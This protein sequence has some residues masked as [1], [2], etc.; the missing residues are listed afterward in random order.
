MTLLALTEKSF[1]FNLANV[2]VSAEIS[3]SNLR[4]SVRMEKSTAP[5]LTPVPRAATKMIKDWDESPN[6][7][8]ET[9][10][11]KDKSSASMLKR[12]PSAAQMLINHGEDLVS[13]ILVLNVQ[14]V[15]CFA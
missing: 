1:A 11:R 6:G 9:F 13:P 15:R 12:A 7:S 14:P 8:Q 10:A 3:T 5:T 2:Q 4:A